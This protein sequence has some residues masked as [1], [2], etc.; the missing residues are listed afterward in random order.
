MYSYTLQLG[1]QI[2]RNNACLVYTVFLK[3]S[4]RKAAPCVIFS[5]YIFSLREQSRFVGTENFLNYRFHPSRPI[6]YKRF[7]LAQLNYCLLF[8]IY[9]SICYFIIFILI[10]A[11]TTWQYCKS[12]SSITWSIKF[13]VLYFIY[14]RWWLLIEAETC[15]NTIHCSILLNAAVINWCLPYILFHMSSKFI[16]QLKDKEDDGNQIPSSF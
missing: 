4:W 14:T 9:F 12:E 2:H 10:S 3:Q 5:K 13:I 7:F 11:L 1:K 15:R 8:W 6:C 16:K